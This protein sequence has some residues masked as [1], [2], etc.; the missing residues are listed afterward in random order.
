LGSSSN[1]EAQTLGLDPSRA[2]S[3]LGWKP[4]WSQEEAVSSSI[5]WW[6]KVLSKNQT[7]LEACLTDIYRVINLSREK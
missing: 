6:V 5:E 7:P 3:S 2:M 4:K 1:S